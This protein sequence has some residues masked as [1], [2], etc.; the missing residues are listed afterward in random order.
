MRETAGNDAVD[1]LHHQVKETRSTVQSPLKVILLRLF[2]SRTWLIL[3]PNLDLLWVLNETAEQI[4]TRRL[5]RSAEASSKLS[6]G[7]SDWPR[8]MAFRQ[9]ERPSNSVLRR[10]TA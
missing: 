4:R 1:E 10:P 2:L 9:Q 8:S 3:V 7:L 5:E 6:E